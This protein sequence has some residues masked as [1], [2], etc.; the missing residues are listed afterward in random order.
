[1]TV[2]DRDGHEITLYA[3]P[4]LA[5]FDRLQVGDEVT[6]R[7]SEPVALQIHKLD[8]PAASGSRGQ[9]FRGSALPRP[10]SAAARVTERVTIENLDPQTNEITF[11]TEDGMTMTVIADDSSL[12]KDL[13][14][15]SRST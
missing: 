8:P 13:H 15:A 10:G 6:F 4:T 3:E 9:T 1:V 2:Q 12:L 5:G 7:Y 11:S 14:R